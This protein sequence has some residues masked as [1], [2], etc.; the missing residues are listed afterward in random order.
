MVVVL[1]AAVS[2]AG[3]MRVN[4]QQ[5]SMTIIPAPPPS[6]TGV[7]IWVSRISDPATAPNQCDSVFTSGES[8]HVYFRVQT[9]TV[10]VKIWDFDSDQGK[11]LLFDEQHGVPQRVA[12]GQV[13]RALSGTIQGSGWETLVLQ[14]QTAYGIVLSSGCGL[15][16]GKP[17]GQSPPSGLIPPVG[18][19]NLLREFG[20]LLNPDV[21]PDVPSGAVSIAHLGLNALDRGRQTLYQTGQPVTLHYQIDDPTGSGLVPVAVYNV[22]RQGTMQTL[23]TS[24]A[25]PGTE[26]RFNAEVGGNIGRNTV[27][28]QTRLNDGS[29][30]TSFCSMHVRETA[31]FREDFEFGNALGL[32][33][34]HGGHTPWFVTNSSWRLGQQYAAQAGPIGHSQRSILEIAFFTNQS[35]TLSFWYKVSSESCCDFLRFYINHN[36]VQRWAGEKGWAQASFYLPAGLHTLR[37]E[38]TKDSSDS[39]G[40]DTAWLDDIYF[41]PSW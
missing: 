41:M 2:L 20:T 9:P 7:E 15:Q 28:L 11:V 24:Q 26:Y 23:M 40:Q 10:W 30:I 22:T 33:W 4:S 14:V 8:I 16:V 31:S 34:R 13:V 37:W 12:A 5:A 32:P 3:N 18:F 1:F 27:V 39:S 21:P 35:G 36:E 25:F 29:W 38:Y 6:W 19:W 17:T